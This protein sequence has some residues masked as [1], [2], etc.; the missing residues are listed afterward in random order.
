MSSLASLQ[1][2]VDKLTAAVAERRLRR[3]SLTQRP[4]NLPGVEDWPAFA[5]RTWIRTSGKFARFDPYDYQIDLIDQINRSSNVVVNKSR[6]MGA[7]ETVANYLA[8]RAATEPGFA[9]VV[10]S[11]TQ[12][13][14]SDL[15]RRVRAMLNSIDGHTFRYTTDSNTLVS[16][17]GG[18]VLYFLPGSPRAARGIP[19]GSVLWIDEAAFV[20]GAADIYRGAAPVLSMLGD[21]AKVIVTST[22]DTLL[23]FF[24]D[25]WHHN[26]SPSWY[27][28]VE[29]RDIDGL[30][31]LLR[32][33]D[34]SWTR[35][36][37]HWSQ[38][39]IYGADTDWARKTRESRRLTQAAWLSEYELSF[40]TT[41]T[42]IYPTEL[43]RR[44]ARGHWREC[45]TIYRDYIIGIDPN[46]GG[47]DYFV[48]M[49]L[50]ITEPPHEVVAMYRANGRSTDYSLRQVCELI[51]NFQPR[52][53]I[54]E[55]Q[56]MGKVIAEALQ[57]NLPE[58]AIEL[59]NTTRPAKA[60]ATDR[61]LYLL[62]RD[63][64][65]FPDG[66]ITTELLAF[67]QRDNGGREAAPGHHDDAVMALAI[68]C[69]LIPETPQT[70]GFFANI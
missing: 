9:G 64:L 58:Y 70:A 12:Q 49:V 23:D 43:V 65:I 60:T 30:N 63:E 37:I 54:V 13:D 19:S 51:E 44:A 48:A 11:K 33:I 16:I 18:G 20:D 5:R 6:Q 34:D 56:A 57:N 61:I 24:G 25:L 53:V 46:A 55:Q 1:R 42:Q 52:R 3:A 27:S 8:C 28:F 4:T 21:A 62:E 14:A 40:G 2:R 22:P 7:S 31:A 32:T 36:A 47:R 69:S 59:F 50:D 15:G 29:R 10:F 38:H 66:P 35:V 68:A 67:Q 17:V 39:P 45:G 26:L 41:D